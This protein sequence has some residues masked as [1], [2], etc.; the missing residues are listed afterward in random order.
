M[1][2]EEEVARAMCCGERCMCRLAKDCA[3]MNDHG[4][5]ARGVLIVV[6]EFLERNG[7]DGAAQLIRN[8]LF[9]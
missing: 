7:Q 1:T 8:A 5:E 2:L 6:K 9:R 3:A 4:Y